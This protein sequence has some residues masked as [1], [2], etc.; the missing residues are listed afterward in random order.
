MDC[1]FEADAE[2]ATR[3]VCMVCGRRLPR[4]WDDPAKHLADCGGVGPRRKAKPKPP[5]QE[6]ESLIPCRFRGAELR[7]EECQ[8]CGGSG[9]T[10]A[11]FACE[12]FGECSAQRIKRRQEIPLCTLCESRKA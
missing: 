12:H 3:V 8:L 11:V 1:D 2:D 9:R 7:R 5:P 6:P 10:I 4:K